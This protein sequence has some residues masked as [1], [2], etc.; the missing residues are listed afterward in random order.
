[1]GLGDTFRLDNFTLPLH[2][3]TFR[4]EKGTVTFLAPVN[5]TVTGAIFIGRPELKS[6]GS[7]DVER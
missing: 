4:F 3:A 7:A 6:F 1:V 2:V 5:G